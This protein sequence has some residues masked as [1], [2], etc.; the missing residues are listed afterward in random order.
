MQNALQD[1]VDKACNLP[2]GRVPDLHIGQAF[3]RRAENR[4]HAKT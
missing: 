3:R 4:L 1:R 2:D